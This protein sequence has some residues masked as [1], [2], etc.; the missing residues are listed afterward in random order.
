MRPIPAPQSATRSSGSDFLSALSPCTL[1]FRRSLARKVVEPWRSMREVWG[2]PPS[3]P[4]MSLETLD[5]YA[6]D[7]DGFIKVSGRWLEEVWKGGSADMS[8]E[9]VRR[10]I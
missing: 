3:M 2:K 9:S 1:C 8:I 7:W 6:I 4:L 5:Q 10:G